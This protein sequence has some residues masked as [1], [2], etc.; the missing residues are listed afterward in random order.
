M[1][2]W[3][4]VIEIAVELFEDLKNKADNKMDDIY[5]QYSKYCNRSNE[6]LARIYR[7]TSNFSTK[8][9][10]ELIMKERKES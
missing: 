3:G 9:A 5:I 4:K 8:R 1:Q 6:E 2:I 10:I 7:N